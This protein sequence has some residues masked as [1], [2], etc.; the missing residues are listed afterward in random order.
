MF[1]TNEAEYSFNTPTAAYSVSDVIK[2]ALNDLYAL[3]GGQTASL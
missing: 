3:Y 1:M 2:G